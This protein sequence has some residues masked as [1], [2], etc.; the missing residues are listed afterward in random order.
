MA[1][2]ITSPARDGD[3]VF[4]EGRRKVPAEHRAHD[5]ARAE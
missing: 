4:Y 1:I 5:D 2:T 3:G